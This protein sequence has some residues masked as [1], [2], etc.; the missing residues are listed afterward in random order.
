MSPYLKKK[1]KKKR[2]TIWYINLTYG[3]IS[4]GNENE[5]FASMF[6]T[7]LSTRIKIWKQPK[8]SSVGE[9]I[10][11]EDV[12]CKRE[13]YSV[14]RKSV[15][16]FGTT[17]VEFE[18]IMWRETSPKDRWR[19]I[20]YNITNVRWNLMKPVSLEHKL[21]VVIL[22][23]WEVGKMRRYCPWNKLPVIRWISSGD[24]MYSHGG[25]T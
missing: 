1:K 22:W 6:F 8:C 5:M 11:K 4:K 14:M 12:T 2:T 24:L 17:W 18:G 10:K 16:L 13:Y 9:W 20:L 19:Q 3:Y 7:A 15:L 25:Y 23:S 21:E